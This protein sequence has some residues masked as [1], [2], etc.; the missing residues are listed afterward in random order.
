[1][2]GVQII[3]PGRNETINAPDGYVSG[4]PKVV[5]ECLKR[6]GRAEG[7]PTTARDCARAV[8]LIFDAYR[9]AREI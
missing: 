1:M 3:G 5:D 8:S 4:W 6:I 9:M 7:P 2:E